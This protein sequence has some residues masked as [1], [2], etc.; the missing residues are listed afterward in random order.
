M[1]LYGI[2]QVRHKLE[3]FQLLRVCVWCMYVCMVLQMFTRPCY[4][5]QATINCLFKFDLAKETELHSTNQHT[6]SEAT[7][8]HINTSTWK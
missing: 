3:F 8:L 1:K 2:G 5:N 6:G 4:V 7:Q